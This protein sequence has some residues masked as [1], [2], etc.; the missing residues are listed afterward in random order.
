LLI[1]FLFSFFFFIDVEEIVQQE[2]IPAA[3]NS[4]LI[5]T[6]IQFDTTGIHGNEEKEKET[7]RKTSE[8]EKRARGRN[9]RAG[10]TNERK[11]SKKRRGT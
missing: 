2:S 9:E 8:R 7:K 10:E 5:T 1:L 6:F 4:Q 3:I 11:T